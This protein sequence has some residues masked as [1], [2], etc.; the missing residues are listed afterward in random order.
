V[1]WWRGWSANA[2]KR[3]KGGPWG[4]EEEGGETWAGD[5]EYKNEDW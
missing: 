2:V 1:R 3:R 4:V 5:W